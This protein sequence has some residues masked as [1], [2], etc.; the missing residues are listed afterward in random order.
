MGL[1]LFDGLLGCFMFAFD[2]SVVLVILLT[3]FVLWLVL[4]LL[5][6]GVFMV[7]DC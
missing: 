6:F 2:E 5:V 3:I 4:L 7:F 1:I